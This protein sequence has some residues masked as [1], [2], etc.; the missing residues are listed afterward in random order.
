MTIFT[1]FYLLNLLRDILILSQILIIFYLGLKEIRKNYKSGFIFLFKFFILFL[2]IFL[3]VGFLKEKFPETR[4]LS[5]LGLGFEDKN[6]FPSRHTALSFTL[7]FLLFYYDFK[8][9]LFSLVISI[10]I[11]VLSIVSLAHWPQDVIFGFLIGF[12]ASLI[13]QESLNFFHRLNTHKFKP[14]TQDIS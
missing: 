9:F 4:P 8:I 5:Y 10:L 13:F 14:E 1:Y 7:T 3:I 6:S 11:A 2:F 12:L